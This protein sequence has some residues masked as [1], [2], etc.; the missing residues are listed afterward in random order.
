MAVGSESGVVVRPDVK[1]PYRVIGNGAAVLMLWAA[2]GLRW[3]TWRT[4]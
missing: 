4:S 1:L 2:Q 3:T